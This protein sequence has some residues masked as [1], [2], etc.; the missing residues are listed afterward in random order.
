MIL[1]F[2]VRCYVV[3]LCCCCG[4]VFVVADCVVVFLLRLLAADIDSDIVADLLMLLFS[5]VFVVMFV[6]VSLLCLP[7]SFFCVAVVCAAGFVVVLFYCVSVFL[8]VF[9]P[10]VCDVFTVVCDVVIAVLFCG[11][12]RLLLCVLLF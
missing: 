9:A 8:V 11:C 2:F 3:D 1:L 6:V 7:L 10:G 4:C 5:N 12:S